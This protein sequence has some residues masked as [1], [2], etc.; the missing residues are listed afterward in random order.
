MSFLNP[1]VAFCNYNSKDEWIL[2]VG[3]HR[4]KVLTA[5]ESDGVRWVGAA[6][7]PTKFS[8]D[9]RKINF[10][11][12]NSS[13]SSRV[14][15]VGRDNLFYFDGVDERRSAVRR[16]ITGYINIVWNVR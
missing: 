7:V 11:E 1:P 14:I 13:I 6:V 10:L 2:S 16:I 12:I 9:Q 4:D 5:F 3:V 15:K 8:V